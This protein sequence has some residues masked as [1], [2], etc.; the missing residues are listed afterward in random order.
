MIYDCIIIYNNLDLLR[1]RVAEHSFVDYFVISQMAVDFHH[2]HKAVHPKEIAAIMGDRKY[3]YNAISDFPPDLTPFEMARYWRGSLM[4]SLAYAGADLDDTIL[5]TDLDEIID[6]RAFNYDASMGLATFRL[7]LYYYYLNLYSGSTWTNGF[8]G[9]YGLVR[10]YHPQDL[11]Y[12]YQRGKIPMVRLEDT[13]WHFAWIGGRDAILDK[14]RN[15]GVA[16]GW[17]QRLSKPEY[18]DHLL[19]NRL[20]F[21]NGAE[22][23]LVP[24]DNTFPDELR[25]NL[26]RYTHLLY[27]YEKTT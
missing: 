20:L 6:H 10:K 2:Q 1:L 24:I 9:P 16:E 18:V 5:C 11:R 14:Y 22:L 25:Y 15:F 12:N 23:E 21:H 4:T 17:D 7:K 3:H 8:I 26:N 27:E 13:G 19:Q